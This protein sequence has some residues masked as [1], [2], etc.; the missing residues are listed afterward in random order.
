MDKLFS[1]VAVAIVVSSAHVHTK[2]EQIPILNGFYIDRLCRHFWKIL[3]T[4]KSAFL[5]L[6]KSFVANEWLISVNKWPNIKS[7]SKLKP[8]LMR[9]EKPEQKRKEI[10]Y[11]AGSNWIHSVLFIQK[12]RTAQQDMPAWLECELYKINFNLPFCVKNRYF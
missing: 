10:P 1:Y 8:V 11:N 7:L 12:R 6:S 9:S 3:S 2:R 5:F 4:L